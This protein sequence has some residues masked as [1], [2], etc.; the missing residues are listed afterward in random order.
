LGRQFWCRQHDQGTLV[1]SSQAWFDTTWLTFLL[2]ALGFVVLYSGLGHKEVRF[3]FPV[4]PLFNLLAAV[5]V[6]RLHDSAF[7]SKGKASTFGSRLWYMAAIVA[8]ILSFMA[9]VVFVAI[10]RW[11]YPGG[12]ALQI[13]KGRVNDAA[14]LGIVVERPVPQVHV[15]IDVASA[16]TGVNL[17]G[18][19]SAQ[20]SNPAIDWTFDKDGYE[21]E[22][23][24]DNE[25]VDWG[26]FTHLLTESVDLAQNN[27]GKFE[28]VGVARGN[29][30]LDIR[31]GAIVTSDAIYV[32]ERKDWVIV[33][34]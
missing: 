17:F 5:G 34:Q 18:Q 12:I 4:L 24:I 23:S 21:I 1:F 9:S 11:N 15:H 33:S 31:R 7:P 30:R 22:N 25:A 32:L 8:I 20:L 10:S 2:P 29:P 3:L 16:M 28:V 6:N 19:R 14:K 27:G 26:V 13:V